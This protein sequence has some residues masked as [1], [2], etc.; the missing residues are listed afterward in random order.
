MSGLENEAWLKIGFHGLRDISKKINLES[1]GHMQVCSLIEGMTI[2]GLVKLDEKSISLFQEL[3]EKVSPQ[4]NNSPLM[5][6]AEI[7]DEFS[8]DIE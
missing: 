6:M 8:F 1:E 3:T 2:K 4:F 7:M 5:A